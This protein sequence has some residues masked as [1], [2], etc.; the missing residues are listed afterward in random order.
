MKWYQVF[1]KKEA[2]E[3]G[4]SGSCL[5]ILRLEMNGFKSFAERTGIE[6]GPGITGIVGPNG[7][8]KSNVSDALRWVLGEQSA[9]SLRGGKMEDVIFSGSERL[10]RVNMAQ[11]T[12]VLNNRD[13]TLPLDYEEVVIERR[14]FRDGE[15]EYRVNGQTMRLKDMILLFTDTGVGKDAF[16]IIGQGRIDQILSTRPEDRRSIF[17]EVAGIV[18]I[19]QRKEEAEAKLQA[20]DQDMERVR[21]IT[22]EI[23]SQLAPLRKE[24]EQA[25]AYLVEKQAYDNLKI[26]FLVTD[27]EEGSAELKR[28]GA[29]KERLEGDLSALD[30]KRHTLEA[31]L[32]KH[33]ETLATLEARERTLSQERLEAVTLVERLSGEGELLKVRREELKSRLA[34]REHQREEDSV[35]KREDEEALEAL[36]DALHKRQASIAE[37]EDVLLQ[38]E[39]QATSVEALRAELAAQKDDYVDLYARTV[40]L[41]ASLV[42]ATET[43]EKLRRDITHKEIQ[44]S[45]LKASWEEAH[46][47][48]QTIEE[49]LQALRQ[50]LDDLRQTLD[51]LRG[52]KHTLDIH[53]ER[54]NTQLDAATLRFQEAE[55]R[56]KAVESGEDFGGF[57]EG[58]RAVLAAAREGRLHGVHGAVLDLLRIPEEF[59]LPVEVV[60]GAQLTHIVVEDEK[61]AREAIAYLK[62]E[63][64]GRATFLP[65]TTIR[66][67]TLT[68]E[69]RGIVAREPRT[70]GVLQEMVEIDAA[71]AEILAYLLGTTIVTRDLVTANGLAKKLRHR[72]RIVTLDGDLVHPGGSMTGGG[73]K[74]RRSLFKARERERQ[75]EQEKLKELRARVDTLQRE[76]NTARDKENDLITRIRN[77]EQMYETLKSREGE[78]RAAHQSAEEQVRVLKERLNALDFERTHL[79]LDLTTVTEEWQSLQ[80]RWESEEKKRAALEQA[81]ASL[82]ARLEQSEAALEEAQSSKNEAHLTLVRLKTVQEHEEKL[83]VEKKVELDKLTRALG[84][85]EEEI[86]RIQTELQANEKA[87]VER[88]GRLQTTREKLSSLEREIS[89]LLETQA[90]LKKEVQETSQTLKT[91]EYERE[92]VRKTL[93]EIETAYTRTYDRLDQALKE[94]GETY[95]LTVKAARAQYDLIPEEERT[96]LKQAL[97]LH[98]KRFESFGL[99]NLG[100]IEEAR[101]LEERLGFLQAQLQD[102]ERAKA[103]L[104]KLIAGIEQE[105]L[106]RFRETFEGIRHAFR[107]VFRA[108][109]GGGDADLVFMDPASPLTSGIE[110]M[111]EPPGKK[112]KQ[113][114]LLSGGERA[115]TALSL[116]FA[117]LKVRPVPFCVLDEVDSALD[118]ANVSRFADFLRTFRKETQFIVITHR[119]GTMMAADQLY[120]VTMSTNGTSQV[121]SV[122]LKE[123]RKKEILPTP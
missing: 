60:L 54:L 58:T 38:N 18:K 62:A 56:L 102:M 26:R 32:L 99:V 57:H 11:V 25:E 113:L 111:V 55:A 85:I 35:K 106:T 19:K 73:E 104:K 39:G 75:L 70:L 17:E 114:S 48:V 117:I 20:T 120:G 65:L 27:I 37:L 16:S 8:G 69:E 105:M 63:G 95:R 122:T 64:R 30:A 61:S 109:F 14:L 78:L 79:S 22:L 98:K 12:L 107:D 9:R 31:E 36:R 94:L 115:L 2:C 100:A 81:I 66:G 7:S 83:Y 47:A 77:Q 101:R 5:H 110:L 86:K 33:E 71:Y 93:Y 51:V 44:A 10:K 41:H 15:S 45:S 53:R 123:A 118:E 103:A 91:I 112:M 21:D 87:E 59:K 89:R 119:R 116:L 46:R 28:L 97:S 108:L 43:R 52:E 42:K 80:A 40:Q 6:F 34:A 76:L 67:R 49:E 74:S 50:T 90:A 29:E 96:P 88:Q 13:R 4:E 24:K 121:L 3:K 68:H 23:E 82:E 1:P 72:Y 92:T 84:T